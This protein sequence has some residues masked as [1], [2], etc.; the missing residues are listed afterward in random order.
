MTS[1]DDELLDLKLWKISSEALGS[2]IE[3]LCSEQGTVLGSEQV[4]DAGQNT[5]P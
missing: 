3:R 5:K 4:S 2:N 1:H